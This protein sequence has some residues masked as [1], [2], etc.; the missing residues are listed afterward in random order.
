MGAKAAMMCELTANSIGSRITSPW[1]IASFPRQVRFSD[2][3]SASVTP[4]RIIRRAAE[5]RV[6]I[7]PLCYSGKGVPIG[8]DTG[9]PTTMCILEIVPLNR[10]FFGRPNFLN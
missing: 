9:P 1:H 10:G 7:P 8:A 5:N 4:M 2:G 3:I 6:V